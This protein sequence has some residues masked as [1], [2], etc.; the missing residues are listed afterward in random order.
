MVAVV[1]LWPSGVVKTVVH[2][3]RFQGKRLA[4][5]PRGALSSL[6]SLIRCHVRVS[7]GDK[8]G[9]CE[10]SWRRIRCDISHRMRYVASNNIHPAWCGAADGCHISM[11]QIRIEAPGVGYW[12]V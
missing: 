8:R 3:T 12:S 5:A 9:G 6:K 1:S 4:M 7:R 10:D 11:D 2:F